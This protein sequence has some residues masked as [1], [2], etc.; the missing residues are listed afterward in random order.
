MAAIATIILGAAILIEGGTLAAISER[1]SAR[2]TGERG[3]FTEPVG[4][5]FM[6][7]LA[8]VVLGILALLGL[9][10]QTLLS[11]SVLVLG[12]SFLFSPQGFI[13]LAGVV[14]GILAVIGVAPMPLILV[15]LLALGV[16]ALVGGGYTAGRAYTSSQEGV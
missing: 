16:A 5:D 15:G 2:T 12:A 4:L 1:F 11:I 10:A 6:G 14:L 7:G 13:G 9:D 3:V 8:A